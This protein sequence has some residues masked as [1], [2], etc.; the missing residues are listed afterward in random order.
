VPTVS[1]IIP[2]YNGAAY[3]RQAIDSV[4]AQRDVSVELIVI[5]DGSTDDT[6]QVLESY[7]DAL[8]KERQANAGPAQARNLGARRATGEWLAF[9]D[10]DDEWLPDKLARQLELAGQQAGLVYTDRRNIGTCTHVAELQSASVPQYEGDIFE[11]LLRDNFITMSSVLMHRDWFARLGGFADGV[12]GCDDW[13]LWLRYAAV[14]GL[15]RL[16]RE[17][18]TLY[19]WHAN[20]ISTNQERMCASRLAVIQRALAS[21]RG[22]R[23]SRCL[24]PQALAGAWQCSALQAAPARRW[25]AIAWY[26][27]SA[28]YWPWNVDVYKGMVKCCLGRA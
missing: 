14:G 24:A 6:W 5:D 23:V 8:H 7:G 10:A 20:S 21:P 16:C 15:V 17:P 2:V 13:D 19:R 27:R 4:L 12:Y 22:Q 26:L 3:L 25:Q 11:P 9:L 18:L 28:T 1:T